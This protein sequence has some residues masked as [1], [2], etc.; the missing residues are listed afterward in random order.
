[1]CE[2]LGRFQRVVIIGDSLVRNIMSTFA[3]LLR[4]DIGQG[5]MMNWM[6]PK[7]GKKECM[8]QGQ[9]ANGTSVCFTYSIFST[10]EIMKNDPRSLVCPVD[11][12]CE[13]HICYLYSHNC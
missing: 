3:I 6:L 10:D 4:Q 8:C 13:Y 9:F 7:E 11:M 1:M 5:A 2:I 12:E